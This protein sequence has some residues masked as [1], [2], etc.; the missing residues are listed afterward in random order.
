[1]ITLTKLKFLTLLLC[2]LLFAGCS[3]KSQAA[4]E[5]EDKDLFVEY[6]DLSYPKR[7]ETLAMGELANYRYREKG[8]SLSLGRRGSRRSLEGGS[9][10]SRRQLLRAARSAIGTP[11]VV[12]GTSPG[13]FDCS[14]LVCWAYGNVGIK[15]P[16]TARE[17]SVVGTQI[18]DVED[19][20]AGDIVAFRHPKRGYHTGIYV[21]DGK[22][23]HSPR[24]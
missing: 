9:M 18:R 5:D 23:I 15:L 13:G 8:R 12:G 16:R 7:I 10:T 17:Q 20:Q 21:G 19:M 22:F 24:L 11:Y 14:G 6:N 2:A 1:M 4:D 3:S